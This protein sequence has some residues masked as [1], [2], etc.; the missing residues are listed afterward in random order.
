MRLVI[1][2]ERFG[3]K[4][5]FFVF[6]QQAVSESKGCFLRFPQGVIITNEYDSR[7]EG[8][9]NEFR[10]LSGFKGLV[11]A[12]LI[13]GFYIFDRSAIPRDFFSGILR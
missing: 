13:D 12:F 3:A 5:E 11:S 2:V 9:L 10:E 4:N 6:R 1:D 8:G 7:F